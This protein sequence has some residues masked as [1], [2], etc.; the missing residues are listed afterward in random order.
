M[1]SK[2]RLRR[3]F[4]P[5]VLWIARQFQKAGIT[6][7][8]VSYLGTLLAV[9]GALLF[10]FLRNYWGSLLFGIFIFTAGIFDGVDGS[11]ARL[12]KKASL[13][14]GFLDSVLDRYADIVI[15]IAFLGHFSFPYPILGVPMLLWAI[16]AVIGITMVS[17]VRSRAE[18][19]GVEDCDVGLVA[20]SERLFIFFI[21]A[22]LNLSQ[23]GLMIVVILAHLT[24]FYRIYH[25]HKKTLELKKTF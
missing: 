10:W 4:R 15:V 25:T 19:I 16:L 24:A 1:G 20:R 11:L 23:W 3:I 2:Y 6:P 12:T 14:G 5:L 7:N 13:Y 22:L 9:V 18:A 17:Y 21:F 8:Q